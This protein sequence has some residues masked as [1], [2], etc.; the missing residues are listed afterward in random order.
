MAVGLA[1]FCLLP[2][3]AVDGG[4]WSLRWLLDG[5]PLDEDVAPALFLVAPGREAVAGADRPR[6]CSC[7][8]SPGGATSPTRPSA[9]CSCVIGALGLGWLVA[10]GFAIGLRGWRYDWLEALF[11]E[12]DGRQFGM[13]YGALATALAFLFLLTLGIAARGAVGGDVFVVGSIG[14]VI[15]TV[16]L[17]VF[18]PIAQMLLNAFVT[19][20]RLLAGRLRRAAVQRPALVARLPDRR[21][22][23]RRRLELLPPRRPRR[24]ALDAARP[25]L[26]PR[27]HPH[28]LPLPPH[29]AR[30]HRAADHHPRL[31]DRPRRHPALRPLRVLHPS[32]GRR[33]R[34]AADPLG[35]RPARPLDRPDARLHPDRLPR[36]DRRRRG[37]QPVDGGG[38]ADAAR[39]PL[40]DLRHRHPA[41]DA[42]RPRQ[43]LPARLHRVDGRLRQPA[44]ARAATSTCSRPRSSSRSSAP[45]TT[46]AWPRPSPSCS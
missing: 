22:A 37:R 21:P 18:V 20:D 1:G 25:R 7:R 6:S 35:L 23:L 33:L 36:A 13:G 32:L 9:G 14:F 3:Y 39:R 31:R 2:W 16:T 34:H 41:A 46:P 19:E 27:R 5:W 8:C 43:R 28:R 40:A 10:Q 24:R 4:F 17:F 29:P 44:G 42:P 15:A 45:R 38:G 11:G 30:A 26:R 12:L